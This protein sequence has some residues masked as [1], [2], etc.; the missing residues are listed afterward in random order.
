MMG[1]LLPVALRVVLPAAVQVAVY[2]VI[3]D[4]PVDA[5]AVKLNVALSGRAVA[6][7]SVGALGG[8][9]TVT[10]TLAAVPV[11]VLLTPATV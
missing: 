9:A 7:V 2:P 8:E 5:G 3:G 1:E 6:P 4:P 11:P 10:V